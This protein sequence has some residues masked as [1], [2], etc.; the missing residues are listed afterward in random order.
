M[1]GLGSG[2][3]GSKKAAVEDGLTLSISD[4]VRKKALVPGSRT[5]GTWMWSYSGR[6]PHARIGYTADLSNPNGGTMQLTYTTNG[7]PMDYVVQLVSTV[8]TYG[9][10][11]WWF[12]CP[13]ARPDGGP[14]RRVTK[15]HLPP[16][17]RYFGSRQ[18][19]R[20]T[21]ESC[22]ESG[23]FASLHR[24]LASELGMD[25]ASVRRSLKRL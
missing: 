25:A 14:P 24:R 4:L 10:R 12:L 7:A 21:Y 2:Y 22:R 1:G 17:A 3:Q 18:A 6:E 15:L 8:P 11:R 16:G 19:Y 5:Y 13:L 9:G 23:K 20:L